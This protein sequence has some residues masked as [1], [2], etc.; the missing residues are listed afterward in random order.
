MTDHVIETGISAYNKG[1]RRLASAI[2]N[3]IVQTEP[4]HAAAWYWLGKCISDPEKA[5]YCFDR[6]EQLNPYA[7]IRNKANTE[8]VSSPV[9][10]FVEAENHNQKEKSSPLDEAISLRNEIFSPQPTAAPVEIP[11]QKRQ[12]KPKKK[13]GL[14]WLFVGIIALIVVL[15]LAALFY[16]F[17]M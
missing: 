1:D 4:T 12:V 17:F 9:M 7:A 8:P 2:F 16:A 3:R 10:S 6:A 14:I 15:A 13:K 5:R 11:Q